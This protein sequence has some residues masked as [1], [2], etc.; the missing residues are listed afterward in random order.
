MQ[1]KNVYSITQL[2]QYIKNMFAQDYLLTS[3]F[4]QGEVSNLKYHTSGHIYFTLKD[5]NAAISCIMFANSRSGLN[6]K[7]ENGMKVIAAGRVDVYE[8]EGKYQLYAD[9]LLLSGNGQ[10]SEQF[11]LLKE[12]LQEMG[13]FEQVYKQPIP[14]YIKTLGVVTAPTGAA[15]RD[16]IQISKRRNPYVQILLYPAIVQGEFAANS[17]VT[18]IKTL[19]KAGV[20]TI[21]VG[22][23]G[24]SI[25][26]LWAFNEECVAT[27][28]FDC[29]VPIISAVGHE[30]DHTICDFVSDLR[31]PTPSAAAELAVYDIND[32]LHNI[33]NLRYELNKDMQRKISDTIHQMSS[34]KLQLQNKSP[35]A[36]MREKRTMLL[37]LEDKL[38]I[39]IKKS[40]NDRKNRLC[41]C[42]EGLKGASPLDKLNQGYCFASDQDGR[43]VNNIDSIQ[44][45]DHILVD[46]KNGQ[47]NT[48]VIEKT[49]NRREYH[50]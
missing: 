40:I 12:R 4:V 16:I 48:K 41:L 44:I 15:V 49:K 34:L 26:D 45:G 50:E 29:S 46:I 20:D 17:I 28:I 38:D 24:G 32:F 30:T 27:A 25:E 37:H 22:R 43:P 35:E 11:E 5:E 42:I 6:F 36:V 19:E 7:M 10:L 47:L 18:G 3:L 13:M 31:A 14:K 39:F 23:G 2:N 1:P 9:R 8:K 33:E 21:I